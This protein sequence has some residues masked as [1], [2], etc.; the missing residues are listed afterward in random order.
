[1][2]FPYYPNFNAK[3]DPALLIEI[4]SKSE[5]IYKLLKFANVDITDK[6]IKNDKNS[7]IKDSKLKYLKA[8]LILFGFFLSIFLD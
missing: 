4:S 5:I 3:I 8:F 2:I 6:F 7:T 1:M